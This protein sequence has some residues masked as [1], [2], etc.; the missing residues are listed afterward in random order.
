MSRGNHR[1]VTFGESLLRLSPP[2]F[3]RFLQTPSF[4]ATFG[5]AEANV[6]VALAAF[7]MDVSYVSVLPEAHA[8][9]DAAIA[10]LRRFGVDTSR[11]VR[12][13]GRLGIYYLETGAGSRPSRVIY[14]RDHSSMALAQPGDISWDAALRDS[15]WFHVTGITPAISASAA[16]LALDGMRQ[17]RNKGLTVSF[18]L[19]YRRNLWKW[20]KPASEVLGEMAALADILI[21]NEEH[22]RIV[23]GAGEL[24]SIQA[25]TD[26]ALSSWPNLQ[27]TAVSLRET[28]GVGGN[29]WSACMNDRTT[30]CISRRYEFPH[31][32]DRIGAGDAFAAGLIYGRLS[33]NG[34]QQA[35]DFAAAA[36]CLKHSIPG[37]FLRSSAA[38]V[39]SLLGENH[40]GRIDR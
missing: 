9:A 36:C 3:E 38:E 15:T 17:A 24:I 18:D 16:A 35:L 39:S 1:V 31:I 6:A 32:V 7:G 12:G 30:S 8:L 11:I 34:A 2:G 20:G 14:D 10:E 21:A 13:K 4:A 22:L 40:S 26:R 28:G 27:A 19:N 5:G 25:V 37:D 23:L 33:L 29:S